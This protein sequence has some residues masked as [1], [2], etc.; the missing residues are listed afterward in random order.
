MLWFWLA[1]MAKRNLHL[2]HEMWRK[3]RVD[4]VKATVEYTG[5]SA[6]I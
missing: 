6:R 3:V 1:G 5:R 2:T 4:L